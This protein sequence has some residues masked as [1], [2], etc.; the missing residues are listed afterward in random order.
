MCGLIAKLL[1]LLPG[2]R[3]EVLTLLAASSSNMPGCLSYIIGKD[4][5]DEN[6]LW[7]RSVKK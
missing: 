1:T 6:V 3:E 4:A 5:G 2:N 7:V